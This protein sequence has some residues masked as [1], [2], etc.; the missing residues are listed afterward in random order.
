MSDNN[1]SVSLV[2]D[3]RL[4]LGIEPLLRKKMFQDMLCCCCCCGV[5]RWIV[6]F[7]VRDKQIDLN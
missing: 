6:A 2:L 5:R 4:L 3:Y 7:D 1:E